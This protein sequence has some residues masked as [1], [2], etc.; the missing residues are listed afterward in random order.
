MHYSS[1]LRQ[2]NIKGKMMYYNALY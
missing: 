2:Y 1:T